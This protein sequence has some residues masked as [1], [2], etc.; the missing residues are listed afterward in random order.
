MQQLT[1][2]EYSVLM[3]IRNGQD[4]TLKPAFVTAKLEDF[5]LINRTDNYHKIIP[6]QRYNYRGNTYTL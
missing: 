1:F 5:G 2:L 3:D 6:G 4:S